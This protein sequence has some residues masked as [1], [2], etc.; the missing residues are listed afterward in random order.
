MGVLETLMVVA[1]KAGSVF[2]LLLCP[3]PSTEGNLSKFIEK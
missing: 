1:E 3:G 2:Y